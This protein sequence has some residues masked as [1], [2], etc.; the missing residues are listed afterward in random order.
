[1]GIAGFKTLL[2]FVRQR[3]PMAFPAIRGTLVFAASFCIVWGIA[4]AHSD[5]TKHPF[6]LEEARSLSSG[7]ALLIAWAHLLFRGFNFPEKDNSLLD[8]TGIWTTGYVMGSFFAFFY[9]IVLSR[10]LADPGIL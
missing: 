3:Y 10:I 7:A 9:L 2:V 1:M 6:S 5:L 8:P 4:F